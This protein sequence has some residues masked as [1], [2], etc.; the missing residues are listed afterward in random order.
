MTIGLV[1]GA[2]A[3]IGRAVALKLAETGHDVGV[4]DRDE[5]AAA[6]TA[7]LVR[8][9]GRRALA[10]T[11]DASRGDEVEAFVERTERELGPVD[12]FLANAG[13]SG[14]HAPIW[15]YDEETFE[16]VWA[17]NTR[18]VFHGIKHVGRRM[19]ERKR[20]A[21][22]VTASTSAIRGRPNSAAYVSSKHGALGLVRVAAL[23]FLPYGVRVNAVAPGPVETQLIAGLIARRDKEGADAL[24]RSARRIGQPDDVASVV[25]FLLSDAARHVNGAAWVIDGGNT[26]D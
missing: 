16:K 22:V 9:I 14:K 5:A 23:D 7:E 17:I 3:G 6:E 19:V 26:V 1:T 20:G 13:I 18:G 12:A 15:E 4:V 10:I 2:G 11:A 25:A 24:P 8:S 21:I